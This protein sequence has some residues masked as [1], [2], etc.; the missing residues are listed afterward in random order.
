M[1]Y[2]SYNHAS[3]HRKSHITMQSAT[4]RATEAWSHTNE[5]QKLYNY[6]TSLISIL[7]IEVILPHNQSRNAT[8]SIIATNHIGLVLKSY[9]HATIHTTGYIITDASVFNFL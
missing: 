9:S 8:E 4:Q 1:P 2:W 3:S 5:V 6:S 7:A